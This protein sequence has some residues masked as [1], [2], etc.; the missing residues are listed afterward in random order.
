MDIRIGKKHAIVSI[1]MNIVLREKKV[2]GKDSKQPGE[3]YWIDIG[4]FGKVEDALNALLD[5]KIRNSD[6]KSLADVIK[7][8]NDTKELIRERV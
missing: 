5:E 3:E 7:V 4:Y 6:A 1:P 2:R 8:I